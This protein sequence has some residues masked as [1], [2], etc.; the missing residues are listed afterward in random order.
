MPSESAPRRDTPLLEIDV[1]VLERN[2]A[3]A[4][5]DAHASGLTLRPH[6][7][8]HKSPEVGLRQLA[9]G[10]VGL[11]LATVSEAEIFADAG[12]NDIFI[13]YPVW[14]SARRAQR[15]R[16][17]AER[18]RLRLGVDSIKTAQRL[19]AALAKHSVEVLV[20]V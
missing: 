14:P 18:I 8:T 2:L 19:G 9:H 3:R 16:D 5:A 17:L 12:F 13:A 4:A 1:D 15:I 11:S 7:K 20:E 10:A 6:A